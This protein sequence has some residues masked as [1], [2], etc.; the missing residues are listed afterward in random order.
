MWRTGGPKQQI[1]KNG[2]KIV[3]PE[4]VKKIIKQN[5]LVG[6]M[7]EITSEEA[8]EKLQGNFQNLDLENA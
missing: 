5:L 7:K 1:S 4:E 8:I 3:G 2:K 6:E